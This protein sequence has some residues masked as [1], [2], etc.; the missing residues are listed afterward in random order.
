MLIHPWD[1]ALDEAEWQEWIADGHDFG[2][3]GVN[4]LPGRPPVAVP[5]H[6]TGEPGHLLIHL[7]RPNPAWEAIEN[8]PNVLFT[9]FGDYA[10]VPGPWRAPAGTPPTD[11][12]PTSYYTAV[13]FTCRA[14]I[15][16]APEAKA[17]LL[18]RQMAHFQPD[19]DHAPITADQP[20]YGRMLSGI[21]GLRLDVTNVRAKF[22]YD[23]HKPVEHRTAVA[24]RLTGR[25]RGLDVPTAAQQRRRLNRVG[26]W[27]R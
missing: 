17:E 14:H 27:K 23:D 11:G 13:Q 5:T 2:I 3:L 25:A 1:A 4:G 10:F 20:P 12:V 15:V 6:F 26:P 8:D 19:G 9:V 22:K 21:R 24:G 7:A 18:R 16:D